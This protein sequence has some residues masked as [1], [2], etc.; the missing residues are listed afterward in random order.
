ME[1]VILHFPERGIFWVSI[2]E[3][4][5]KLLQSQELCPLNGVG[6]ESDALS[7]IDYRFEIFSDCCHVATP[8]LDSIFFDYQG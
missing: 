8:L 5:S 2:S 1:A 7:W 6:N 3:E 4:S